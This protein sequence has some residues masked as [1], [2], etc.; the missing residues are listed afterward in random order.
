MEAAIAQPLFLA[1]KS[2]KNNQVNQE[3]ATPVCALVRN[4]MI[5]WIAATESKKADAEASA[6]RL[7]SA[8]REPG[9]LFV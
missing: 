9:L 5:C 3:I 1:V 4:D 7:F 8:G 2:L 6:F